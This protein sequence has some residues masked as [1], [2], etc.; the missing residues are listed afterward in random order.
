[1]NDAR[2]AARM[3]RKSPGFT[4]IAVALLGAGIGAT[5]VI[6]GALDAVMLRPLPVKNP[7]ELVWMVQKT[8]QLG[9]RSSFP[10]AFYQALR[11]HS[12]TLSSVFAEQ[13]FRVAMNEPRPAEQIEVML[14]TPE[15]FDV[16]GVPA[17]LGRTLNADDNKE[18]PGMIPAVLSYGFWR[19]RF[20]GDASAIGKTITLRQRRYAIAGVMPREFNGISIDVSPDVRLP[21]RALPL[22]ADWDGHAAT[23]AEASNF[24]IAGRLRPAVTL[25]RARAECYSFWRASVM[26]SL[27]SQPQILDAELRRGMELAPLEH[28]TSILR[29]KFG[30]ALELLIA[31]VS[32]LL[33]M[34]CANVAGLV[35]ARGAARQEEIA[36]RLAMGATQWRLARQMLTESALLAGMGA[37]AGLAA[38]LVAT[39]LLARA[40]PPVR[41]LYTS[42]VAISLDIGV[43]RRVLLF[44]AAISA[45]TVLLFGLGPAIG[46]AR[47]SVDSVLRGARAS[48]RWRGRSALM[49]VQ[50]ALC[51]MLLAGAGLLART[52]ERLRGVNPGFDADHLV[53]FSVDPSLAGY[54]AEGAKSFRLALMDRVREIPGVAGAA[55]ASRPVMRGSG[56]KATIVPEGRQ[57]SPG[58][59]LNTSL[60]TVTPEYFDLMGMRILRGRELIA[61]DGDARR[62][63][64]NQAFADRFYP[65]I[66][67][68]GRR[69][70]NG[71]EMYQIAGVV[72]DAKYRSLREPMTPTFYRLWSDGVVEPMQLEVRTRGRP[73]SIIE[74]V[75]QALAALDPALPFTE[76]EVM[77]DEVSASAAMEKLTAMLAS[78]FA[79]LA[80]VLAAIGIYGLLAYAVERKKKEIGIRM[81]LGARPSDIGELIGRHSLMIVSAGAA[82]GL[83]A[84][85]ALAPLMRA[86]LYGVAPWDPVSMASAALFV[87]IVAAVATAI[88]AWDA[89]RVEPASILR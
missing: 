28:G 38:A 68:I 43:N 67:P 53:T 64:V 78:L 6:Y 8:P 83:V 30:T 14:V 45:L 3:L 44:S 5:T 19:R 4:A 33:L 46:A 7:G 42:P 54:T 73:Q 15:F 41:D 72:S 35:L 74:P 79:A 70:K 18:N 58:D 51:T 60:N 2:F 62:V 88:A 37:I 50:V 11:D 89:V 75:R 71:R 49:I 61:S 26:E 39:P 48:G 87:I 66:D 63:V 59:F 76:I 40:L 52:F 32:L 23:L 86:L 82:L 22:I 29:D 81:A 27:G 24:S 13:D 21:L 31:A 80:A 57:Q 9:T 69:F 77:A 34:V 65:E 12:T 1:M 84:A 85:L 16:L 25:A 20:H 17:M 55:V 36:L 56:I 10:Y 47:A